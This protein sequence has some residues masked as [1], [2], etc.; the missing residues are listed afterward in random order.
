[1]SGNPATWQASHAYALGAV[2]TPTVSNGHYYLCIAAGTSGSSEPTWPTGTAG[3]TV[4]DSGA[5]WLD[6]G[7]VVALG[8]SSNIMFFEGENDQIV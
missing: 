2:V 3:N 4:V 6:I 8:S 1:L 5:T 7:A